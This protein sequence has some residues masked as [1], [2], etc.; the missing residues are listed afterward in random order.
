MSGVR[1]PVDWPEAGDF[2]A[3]A[4]LGER[5]ET[6]AAGS[7]EADRVRLRTPAALAMIGC[8]GGHSPY[9]ADL[10]VREVETLLGL[11]REGPDRVVA[12]AMAALDAT[13][14]QA[15]RA[16]VA[17]ALR[18]AK[19]RVALAIAVADLGGL[20]ILEEV[21]A[22]LTRLAERTLS[23]AVEHLLGVARAGARTRQGGF[24]VIGMGKLGAGELNYSS[25]VDL[26]LLYEP[27][28]GSDPDAMASFYGRLARDLVSLMQ[29][30]DADGYV[31]R[32][33]LRLRPDP[34]S[35]PAAMPVDAVLGYYEALGETWERAALS[36]ARPVA[37]DMALGQRFL[38]A[39]GPFIWRRHLD[40]AAVD[41]MR[42]MK[43]RIDRR[44]AGLGAR[45]L[46]EVAAFPPGLRGHDLKLGEGG[47]REIE[48][49]AQTLQL[50]W[51]G[52][53]PG[54]R[55]R[56]TLPA[57]RGLVAS[58]RMP[59]GDANALARA[60]RA[61]RQ[62]E[63]RLQ[64][65]SDR[66]THALPKEADGFERFARFMGERDG[67]AFSA[68]LLA[69]LVPAHRIF[70]DL[71]AGGGETGWSEVPEDLAGLG[72]A[73]PEA[74]AALV[75]RWQAGEPRALRHERARAVFGAVLP[76][77][78]GALSRQREPDAALGRFAVLLERLPAGVQV[79]SLLALNPGLVERIAD[80]LGASPV[81]ADHLAA[82]PAALEGLLAADEVD[83]QPGRT[84]ERE[85]AGTRDGD[86]VDVAIETVRRFVRGEEFRLALAQLEG[87]LDVDRAGAARTALA[88]AAVGALLRRV[89][90]AHEGRFGRVAG[91]GMVVV[92]LGKAGSREMMSG[93]DLDLMLVYDAASGAESAGRGVRALPA[94]SYFGRL[95]Q[96]LVAAVTAR[97]LDGALY[98][99]DMRLRPSGNQGP[100]AVS[101]E[102]FRRY[103][104]ETAWTWE[105][106]ALTRARVVAGPGV[107]RGLV[108][109]AIGDALD[110]AG[111]TPRIRADA[112]SMRA[113]LAR[114]KPPSGVWDVKM[115]AGGLMEVEFVA[116]ALQLDPRLPRGRRNV[117]TRRALAGLAAAGLMER[118]DAR[119]LI[120]ADRFWRTVQSCLRL[121]VGNAAP[122]ELPER[123]RELVAGAVSVEPDRLE[124]RMEA[125][126]VR[127]RELFERYV[128]GS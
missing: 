72:F 104:R 64:M 101:L 20:W 15:P 26:L 21:T 81:L 86:A 98:G 65:V 25:D 54:L 103:H 23:V 116:Q 59:A 9:L 1:L 66:Q 18:R 12:E 92:A 82:V 31:F 56:A 80:L 93:S 79:F 45:T 126:G 47:I 51:G 112:A 36:K 117:E 74:A 28:A 100:V 57:L 109:A 127:V 61:L 102:G 60:Y 8:L 111:T 44:Q 67:A 123:L 75:A 34:G 6:A 19:R 69:S 76:G 2:E 37:G 70:R 55:A 113:R 78:L 110:G 87:R 42:A 68:R 52:R 46:A 33:D 41:D 39:V 122:G 38:D 16:A 5:L 32:V 27:D 77:L 106:M 62:V 71:L 84:L 63:H 29:A 53:E 124:E 17:R 95:S 105:R 89:R 85:L 22:A 73:R 125:M 10:A 119:A 43:A 128:G 35:T 99:V 120:E 14:W 88:D 90:R 48:F 3:A 108:E 118:R 7:A 49:A 114:D 83:P 11:L 13:E 121:M 24:V 97:G 115:R 58:G 30:R 94:S 107:L 40:F 96:A 50:V 4:R 91:G